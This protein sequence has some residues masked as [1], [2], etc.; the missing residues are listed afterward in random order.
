[1]K[2]FLTITIICISLSSLADSFRLE[3]KAFHPAKKLEIVWQATND[4]PRGLWIY[5]VLPEA[6]SPAVI[7]NA[8][9]LGR[10]T[11][12]NLSQTTETP[13][14]DEH[15]LYFF[16]W[17]NETNDLRRFLYIAP[18]LGAMRY[19]SQRDYKA[20][21]EDVPTTEDVVKLAEDVLFQ[22]G[23]DRELYYHPVT[24][25][26]ITCTS[27]K[28]DKQAHQA[29]GP[30][31][32]TVTSRGCAFSRRI[33]G[34]S[35]A[36]ASCFLIQFRSHGEIEDFRLD[37]KSLSPHASRRTLTKDEITQLIKSGQ[38]SLPEQHK[39]TSIVKTAKRL[40]I[41]KIEPVYYTGGP[42]EQLDYVYP[43]ADIEATADWGGT[44]TFQVYLQC[45]ILPST[46]L[47]PVSP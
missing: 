31:I 6:F 11:M 45:P 43:Y 18:S 1:M 12:K 30:G 38:A 10:F 42:G 5:K 14:P 4:L 27:F 21:I 17:N 22:L 41:T 32:T 44:N 19:S 2:S 16:A 34:V 46:K 28:Y 33:D 25:Y 24:G 29:I 15:L 3:G 20:P 40:T 26:D 7:S 39:D 8:M 35:E 9:Q 13:I 47:I 23:I 37:W 36:N